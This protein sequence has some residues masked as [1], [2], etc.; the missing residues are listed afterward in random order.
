MNATVIMHG[1][2]KQANRRLYDSVAG[3]YEAIDGRR[4]PELFGWIRSRLGALA[5]SAGDNV[6]ADLGSGSG[7]VC[8]AAA[9]VF[10]KRIALDLSPLILNEAGQVA[11]MKLAADIDAI[12]L[13]NQSADAITCFAVLH[14]LYDTS[15]LAQEIARVLRPG[16]MFWSDHDMDWDF[17]RRFRWPLAIYRKI[18]GADRRYTSSNTGVDADTYKLAEIRQTGVH[19]GEFVDQ[20]RSAG[21]DV[22]AERHWY[23]LTSLTNTLF[24]KYVWPT[25]CAPLLRVLARKPG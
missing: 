17:Y 4:S 22:V 6:L 2:V 24:G 25:G 18:V 23:G 3:Q 20:L 8:R 10:R 7:V 14:H 12:P 13:A 16:G 15:A 1:L 11:E 9:G 21:L 19:G 5:H